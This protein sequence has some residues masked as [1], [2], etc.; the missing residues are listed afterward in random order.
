[1][2]W[3]KVRNLICGFWAL[4]IVSCLAEEQKQLTKDPGT[5]LGFD[6]L[7]GLHT[8]DQSPWRYETQN[9]LCRTFANDNVQ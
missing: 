9:K 7:A 5:S 1:M 8:Y 6:D 3:L 2:L 4:N